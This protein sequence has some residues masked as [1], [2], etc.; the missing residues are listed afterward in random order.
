M[1]LLSQKDLDSINNNLSSFV[2]FKFINDA[3]C[4]LSIDSVAKSNLRYDFHVNGKT[5][6]LKP[7]MSFDDPFRSHPTT[8]FLCEDLSLFPNHR[9]DLIE[10][11]K[12]RSDS[13]KSE[14]LP[15]SAQLL[16]YIETLEKSDDKSYM[17]CSQPLDKF[18]DMRADIAKSMYD[19][20]INVNNHY[21][22]MDPG[23][24]IIGILS[25][26]LVKLGDDVVLTLYIIKN[27]AAGYGVSINF[28]GK[29]GLSIGISHEDARDEVTP[30]SVNGYEKNNLK[31]HSFDIGYDGNFNPYINF[32]EYFKNI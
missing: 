28:K 3:G 13:I 24:S 32:L 18:S 19:I 20:G 12:A 11:E 27:I 8:S 26:N 25:N 23:E 5:H 2:S 1:F 9:Q 17:L 21:H 4:L 10:A 22:G 30:E 14:A 15:I 16:F 7:F 31:Q 29:G 6:H